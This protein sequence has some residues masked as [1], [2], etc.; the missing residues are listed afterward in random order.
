MKPEIITGTR[1]KLVSILEDELGLTQAY[2]NT[3]HH[4]NLYLLH[5][6][7]YSSPDY[8]IRKVRNQDLYYV[9]VDRFYYANTFIAPKSGAL[10][11]LDA[12]KL[13]VLNF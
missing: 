9:H 4:R 11:Y 8:K 12:L 6:G 2:N 1:E 5:Q 10:T 7:E 13:Q 3:W